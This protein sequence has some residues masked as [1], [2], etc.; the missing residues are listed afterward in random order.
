ME[1]MTSI[2]DRLYATAPEKKHA[3]YT[4]EYDRLFSHLRPHSIRLLEIGVHSGKSMQMWK[5][6]FPLATIVGIDKDEK[7]LGFPADAR[8]KFVQG[9][10]SDTT[11]LDQA[12][13]LAGGDFDIIIDDASHIGYHTARTFSHLFPRLKPG[14]IYI[15]EDIGTA[16]VPGNYDAAPPYTPPEIGIPGTPKIFPSQQHG[17]VGLIKQLIDHVQAPT[18]TGE[19]THYAIER[20]IMITNVAILHKAPAPF[21]ASFGGSCAG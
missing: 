5:E 12:L 21:S 10:Q 3:V 2:A 4:N 1:S 18:F 8:F 13:H 11:V 14:G 20:M 16:F 17:M 9:D 15:I 6:Y 7:P 19:Y